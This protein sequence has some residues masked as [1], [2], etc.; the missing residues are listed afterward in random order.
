VNTIFSWLLK[1]AFCILKLLNILP[2]LHVSK[3]DNFDTLEYSDDW[4]KDMRYTLLALP[5]GNRHVYFFTYSQKNINP[6]YVLNINTIVTPLTEEKRTE[7]GN[8]FASLPP[9][10]SN[11]ELRLNYVMYKHANIANSINILNNKVNNYVAI[12]LVY[13]GLFIFI[14]ESTMKSSENDIIS[15]LSWLILLISSVNLISGLI[16]LH[17]CLKVKGSLISSF[18]AIKRSPT[19]ARLAKNIYLDWQSAY[20]EQLCFTTLIKNIEKSFTYSLIASFLLYSLIALKPYLEDVIPPDK[21][22]STT[23]SEYVLVDEKGSFSPKEL[24]EFSQR[25]ATAT[26]VTFVYAKSNMLGKD[27]LNFVVMSLPLEDNHSVITVSDNII[28]GQTLLAIIKESK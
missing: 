17:Q 21:P 27:T 7:L 16:L 22:M 4:F 28:A 8:D 5:L 15:Y 19:Y 18:G 10:G 9:E 3:D 26:E 13:T 24:L 11:W 2:I 23:E 1:A 12:S 25:L 14:I 6:I 20:K